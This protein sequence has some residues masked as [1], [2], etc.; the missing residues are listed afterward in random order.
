MDA[1]TDLYSLGVVLYEMVAG[2]PPFSGDSPV[3]IAYQHVQEPIPPLAERAPGVPGPYEA[4]VMR[5]LAKDA[6]ARYPDGAAMRADLLRFRDGR[7]ISPAPVAA[8]GVAGVAAG[9]AAAAAVGATSTVAQVSGPA[10]GAAGASAT[11][12]RDGV[13][14]NKRTGWFFVVIIF[15]MVLLGGLLLQ[16]LGVQVEQSVDPVAEFVA[17]ES[18][19]PVTEP[20]EESVADE[21]AEPGTAVVAETEEPTGAESQAEEAAQAEPEDE[22][23]AKTEEQDQDQEP[24]AADSVQ[25]PV[26][27]PTD[28]DEPATTGETPTVATALPRSR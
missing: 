1:R 19:E 7:P 9:A 26:D 15:L 28:L 2:K 6:D 4:I 22:R 23:P 20:V 14:P 17:E 12:V 25:E 13:A 24:V 10:P 8:A 11:G 5:A 3:A 21:P 27:H 16:L 18:T